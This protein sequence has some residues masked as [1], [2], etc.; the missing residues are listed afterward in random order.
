[1]KKV[2]LTLAVVA[3]VALVSCTGKAKE[4]ATD[5]AA[6]TAVLVEEEMIEVVDTVAVDT[7]A[8]TVAADTTVAQ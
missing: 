8:T 5:A 2:F 4:E 6:D 1:M 7:T 3:T